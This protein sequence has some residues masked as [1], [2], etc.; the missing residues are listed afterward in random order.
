MTK[1]MFGKMGSAVVSTRVSS[2]RPRAIESPIFC[3]RP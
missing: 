3:P 1:H 2:C